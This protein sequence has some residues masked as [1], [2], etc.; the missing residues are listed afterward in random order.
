SQPLGVRS[1]P[2]L[3]HRSAVR[4]GNQT[5]GSH[6]VHVGGR[7]HGAGD[8]SPGGAAKLGGGCGG[9]ARRALASDDERGAARRGA[10]QRPRG[11]GRG[12]LPTRRSAEATS[13]P[14][15]YVT[16]SASARSIHGPGLRHAAAS[17]RLRRPEP[18]A[19]RP[20]GT[21]SAPSRLPWKDA[22]RGGRRKFIRPK[23]PRGAGR[24]N[25]KREQPFGGE[26]RLELRR[27]ANPTVLFRCLVLPLQPR[28]LTFKRPV[29]ASWL[30]FQ[31]AELWDTPSLLGCVPS[32]DKRELQ[33]HFPARKQLSD[34]LQT[35]Q[36]QQ[37]VF[38]SK[39]SWL[40]SLTL[41]QPIRRAFRR[42]ALHTCK[43]EEL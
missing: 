21:Q 33:F 31:L 20:T 3:W 42:P 17:R 4:N 26:V 5:L 19:I 40:M 29:Q 16:G 24:G 12:A 32:Y 11:R 34:F 6:E 35:L 15:L 8:S 41:A 2:M 22:T 27:A 39:V 25:C 30:T 37:P 1:A 23:T 18:G 38:Q 14:H 10:A 7:G 36:S 9:S 13:A 43:R 28:T